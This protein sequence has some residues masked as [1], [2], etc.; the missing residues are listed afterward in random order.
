MMTSQ[1]N[2]LKTSRFL[3]L[4]I[5][6]FLGAFNDNVFK[7]ALAILITYRLASL[8]DMNA[9][10]LVTLAA[11]IF[12]LPFFL[13]SAT[14]GQLA[15]K[16][17]KSFLIS[18][19]KLIEIMLMIIAAIGFY[20]QN[21]NLL[22]F[23][24]FSLGVHS[25]F[26]G[27]IKY[28][29]LPEHLHS[30]EL[31][32]GNGLIEAGTFIA[33]LLG[34]IIGGV[35]ILPTY[36]EYMI[37]SLALA[38]AISGFIS[39]RFIPKTHR[40]QPNLSINYNIMQETFKLIQYAKSQKEIFRC[41]FSISWFWLIGAVFLAEFPV[42]A[43]DS[44][45]ANEHVVTL[46]LALFSIGLGIGSVACNKLLKG[47]VHLIYV[48]AS[49]LGMT[50]FTIDLYFAASN[51][52]T[53]LTTDLLSP[54]QLLS[55]FAGARVTLDLLLM[56]ICGGLYTVPLY[57]TMQ[58]LSEKSHRARIIASNNIFNALFMVMAAIGT[59][60]MLKMGLSINHV[61]LTVGIGNGMMTL[62][63]YAQR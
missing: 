43:K 7:N 1:I 47:K 31:I 29:I 8:A 17:E 28:A 59:L 38:I 32:A 53:A 44:L 2:L 12:I 27:P 54:S 41:I 15:D 55:T 19:I 10:I 57:A 21:I 62:Y 49:A 33:I 45:H 4:F 13:F 18:I 20:L 40:Y 14:A 58:H 56:A 63:L 24:L 39:S 60:A 25:T 35:F 11:G 52:P 34:T 3:P 51:M 9:Q 30:D 61:F 26:F 42:F 50:I 5:T 36:G 22:L 16:Y 46:F 6:Q 48:P 23:V 37:S